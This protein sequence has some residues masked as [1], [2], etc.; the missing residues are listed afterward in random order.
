MVLGVRNV[1]WKTLKGVPRHVASSR[2]QENI[3]KAPWDWEALHLTPPLGWWDCTVGAGG[4][5]GKVRHVIPTADH[6]TT[7]PGLGKKSQ[8]LVS[9]T[10]VE[11][12]PTGFGL[13][14]FCSPFPSSCG[15]GS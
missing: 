13:H 9:R 7:C 12:P 10:F 3:G 4:L 14:P 5:S 6:L 1:T 8:S 11:I 2:S 15:G